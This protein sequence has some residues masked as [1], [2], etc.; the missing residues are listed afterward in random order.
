[1][2]SIQLFERNRL[3]IIGDHSGMVSSQLSRF[4]DSTGVR[5]YANFIYH[6]TNIIRY[7]R[8]FLFWYESFLKSFI[9]S[10]NA[11]RTVVLI[12]VQRLDAA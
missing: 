12:A 8:R 6:I 2:R 10:G 4:A 11:G 9:V 1:M 7:A 3:A 5:D